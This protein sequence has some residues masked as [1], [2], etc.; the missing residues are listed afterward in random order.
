MKINL[1]IAKLRYGLSEQ[2]VSVLDL[3]R[4][5]PIELS[6]IEV[7]AYE[8]LLPTR[9]REILDEFLKR[10]LI[11]EV[12]NDRW[13]SYAITEVGIRALCDIQGRHYVHRSPAMKFAIKLLLFFVNGATL[14]F[15]RS[16]IYAANQDSGISGALS[17]NRFNFAQILV[18]LIMIGAMIFLAYSLFVPDKKKF[19]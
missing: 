11:G 6:A 3:F 14:L 12:P 2:E 13:Q 17:G 8:F 7:S 19:K 15:I 9:T 18:D 1:D 5:S 10:G 16:V 4:K